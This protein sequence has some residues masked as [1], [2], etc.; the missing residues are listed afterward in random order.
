M[1]DTEPT[2]PAPEGAPAGAAPRGGRNL[3]VA[4]GVGLG[5]ATLFV[6]SLLIHPLL[7]LGFVAI[8]L[9]VALL[10]L[11]GAF[12]ATK[13]RPPTQ[14]ALV[15]LPVM[16]FGTYLAGDRVVM[17]TLFGALLLGFLLV[18]LTPARGHAVS[19]MGALSLEL[20]WVVVLASS[21]GLLLERE[22]GHWYVMAAT[23]LTV[24]NDIGAYA[25]G[26]NWGR[27]TMAPTISPKKTW[28]GFAGALLSTIVLA[29]ALTAQ[30][31]PEVTVPI[32][33][34]LAV[35]VVAAATLG[36]LA[37][38]L[39]KRDLGVKDLGTIFPGHG[40]VMDRV[41]A[42]LFS[43]PTAHVVLLAFGI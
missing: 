37:E 4:I 41:D 39:L 19:R 21:L 13:V 23:A 28:E 17:P 22:G 15:A 8:N 9:G 1:A 18:M 27:T 2:G 16:L 32:A 42:L 7:F 34:V 3:P 6:G 26:R 31:V 30:V 14:A 38:S 25:F 43:L 11:D 10:E 35:A 5:L 12:A 29:V 24:T 40:G 36:D 33:V 20:L